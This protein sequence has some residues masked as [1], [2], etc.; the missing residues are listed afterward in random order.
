MIAAFAIISSQRTGVRDSLP[1]DNAECNS[2]IC[3]G[4]VATAAR[5]GIR[6]FI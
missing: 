2:M 1:D 4:A 5:C 6:S 3:G